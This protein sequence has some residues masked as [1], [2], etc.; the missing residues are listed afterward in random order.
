MAG[1]VPRGKCRPY[2][3]VSGLH[4]VQAA[5]L[6]QHEEQEEHPG[7]HRAEEVL[8]LLQEAYGSSRDEVSAP[9]T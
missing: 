1:G 6:Q 2:Q 5:Q 9:T 8:P 7:S 3:G 4:G